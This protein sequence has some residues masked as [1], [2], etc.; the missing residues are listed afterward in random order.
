VTKDVPFVPFGE[1]L[2]RKPDLTPTY[3]Q[4]WNVSIQREVVQDTLLSVSYIGSQIVRLQVG[5]PLNLSVYVPGV[6]DANG[7]CFLNGQVTP[8]KVN[9]GAACSTIA[10]TSS[11][12]TLGFLNPAFSN[13]IGKLAIIDNGG[14]QQYHGAA[15]VIMWPGPVTGIAP[16]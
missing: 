9:P 5:K 12:R 1:Y 13:E 3:T 7:N 16:V 10:N 2:F 4:T 8:Y 15:S 6:G 11:R 14:T